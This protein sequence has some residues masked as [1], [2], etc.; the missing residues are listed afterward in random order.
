MRILFIGHTRIGD[1]VLSM[2]L[3]DHLVASHGGGR[4][5]A[6]ITVS[7][8]PEAAALFEAAPCVR[9]VIA[10]AKRR[11]QL[12]WLDL[13]R[14][15]ATARWQLIV[16]LRNSIIPWSVRS[17]RR[18]IIRRPR[19]GEHRVVQMARTLDLGAAPPSPR[20]WTRPEHEAAA[21]RLMPPRG[22]VVAL[23]PTANWRGK[24][25]PAD[26]FAALVDRLTGADGILPGARVAVFGAPD[27][28]HM[29]EDLLTAIGEQRR[30]DLIG[31]GDLLTTYAAM[32]RCALYVGNDSGLMHMAA[33]SGIPTLGLFGPSRPE[34]YAP[35]GSK[36]A[37]VRTARSYEELVGAPGYDRHTTG[38]LMES[39]SV[40]AVE[41][42]ALRLWER[43]GGAADPRVQAKQQQGSD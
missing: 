24:I 14:R 27:E 25:W 6:E 31:K 42:A 43:T 22:P 17:D 34:R 23:G 39:L 15:V 32:R 4:E 13:W 7:C 3:V 18:A 21:E 10:L 12:H 38:T 37:H 35:W 16:D 29:V 41:A 30:L 8:G 26:R 2:G 20:L 28:R 9:C 33:A 1:A 40:D 36:T 5:E 11:G 19:P